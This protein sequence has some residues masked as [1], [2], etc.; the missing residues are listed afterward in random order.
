MKNAEL[1]IEVKKLR[2]ELDALKKASLP[3]V[4]EIDIT[5]PLRLRESPHYEVKVWFMDSHGIYGAY[6]NPGGEEYGLG[7]WILHQWRRDG[8]H[9]RKAKRAYPLDL[10]YKEAKAKGGQG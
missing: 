4:V 1:S 3:E 10:V 8:G 9:L 7:H 2:A 5:R 6:R